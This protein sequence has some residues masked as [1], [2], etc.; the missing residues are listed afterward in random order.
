MT[1]ISS[2][3]SQSTTQRRKCLKQAK[4]TFREHVLNLDKIN[5]DWITVDDFKEA[6]CI[7]KWLA[8]LLLE[9]ACVVWIMKRRKIDGVYHYGR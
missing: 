4:N 5:K 1:T 9:N 8:R 7:P 3:E 2:P 6:L